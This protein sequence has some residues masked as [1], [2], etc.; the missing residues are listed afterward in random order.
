MR[1]RS[2]DET[3]NPITRSFARRRLPFPDCSQ[4][5]SS[6]RIRAD[7]IDS[8]DALE[9]SGLATGAAAWLAGSNGSAPPFVD[10]FCR[11]D[12]SPADFEN[13]LG[14]FTPCFIDVF[15]LAPAY[16]LAVAMLSVRLAYLLKEGGAA[17]FRLRGAARVAK[18]AA[19]A[20]SFFATSVP[21]MQLNGRLANSLVPLGGGDAAAAGIAPYEWPEYALAV[22]AW[23]LFACVQLRELNFYLPEHT[24]TARFPQV[25]VLSANLA[26]LHFVLRLN[27]QAEE[28]NS[29]F[30]IL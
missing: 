4:H 8:S 5:F 19:V 12:L 9:M 10:T 27:K 28:G 29:Y 16:A 3:A 26:K 20:A 7:R 13:E 6:A 24:W 11:P 1:R 14:A 22:V 2:A 30:F 15:I 21:V 25:L 18:A 17:K 23:L